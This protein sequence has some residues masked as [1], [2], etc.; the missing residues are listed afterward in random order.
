MHAL[1][2]NEMAYMNNMKLSNNYFLIY[3]LNVLVWQKFPKQRAFPTQFG[4]LLFLSLKKSLIEPVPPQSNHHQGPC[5]GANY[6][7]D[8]EEGLLLL[9][10][11]DSIVTWELAGRFFIC[12][13]EN[14]FDLMWLVFFGGIFG[15]KKTCPNK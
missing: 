14:W 11:P 7:F 12:F 8:R 3:Y 5:N 13:T 2:H 15:G 1:L 10:I 6:V 4:Q 9:L